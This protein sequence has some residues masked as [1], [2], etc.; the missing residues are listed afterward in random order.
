MTY[1]GGFFDL[2][3]PFALLSG[4]VSV[5]M[6]AMHG[7]TYLAMKTDGPVAARAGPPPFSAPCCSSFSSSA[8]GSG[9]RHWTAIGISSVLAHDL[10]SNPLGKTVVRETGAWL[11]NYRAMPW[12]MA[13]P[14]MGLLG[15]LL[16]AHRRVAAL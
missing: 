11:A 10:A 14:A 3:S 1:H 6:L 2:L 16:A 4:L 7:G 15:A 8:A 5:A 12:T 9:P 13:A